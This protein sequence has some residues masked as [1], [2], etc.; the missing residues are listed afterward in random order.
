MIGT[1]CK[2]RKKED[3]KFFVKTLENEKENRYNF[4]IKN[5]SKEEL[6]LWQK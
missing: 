6:F 2:I 3:K 4:N 1:C 5:K